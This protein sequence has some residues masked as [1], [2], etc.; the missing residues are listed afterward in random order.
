MP[1]L[2]I[3]KVSSSFTNIPYLCFLSGQVTIMHFYLSVR[4][5]FLQKKIKICHQNLQCLHLTW[6]ALDPWCISRNCLEV[7]EPLEKDGSSFSLLFIIHKQLFLSFWCFLMSQ[8]ARGG[9]NVGI[10]GRDNPTNPFPAF[11][12]MVGEQDRDHWDWTE[13]QVR[14]FPAPPKPPRATSLPWEGETPPGQLQW[15][16]FFPNS[17]SEPASQRVGA[18]VAEAGAALGA[19]GPLARRVISGHQGRASAPPCLRG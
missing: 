12:S 4:T 6:R 13:H 1:L 11:A 5:A 17:Q 9:A 16:Y 2:Q 15:S 3:F 10:T 7:V 18:A 19:R 14:P 8:W